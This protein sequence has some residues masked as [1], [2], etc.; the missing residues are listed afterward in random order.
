VVEFIWY[1]RWWALQNDEDVRGGGVLCKWS[2]MFFVNGTFE[3]THSQF[4]LNSSILAT[5]EF[6]HL[7]KICEIVEWE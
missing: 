3:V 1:F 4:H 2:S 7:A 5:E 6:T